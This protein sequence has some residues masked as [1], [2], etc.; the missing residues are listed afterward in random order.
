MKNLLIFFLLFVFGCKLIIPPS[1]RYRI[2]QKG[3]RS[4]T[5]C[6]LTNMSISQ[7]KRD[8][9]SLEDIRPKTK[10]EIYRYNCEIKEGFIGSSFISFEKNNKGYNWS[11]VKA[12]NVPIIIEKGYVYQV[13][14][15][16]DL[17]GSYYFCLDSTSQKLIVQYQ[18]AGPW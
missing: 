15:L 10:I 12:G 9:V 16:C 7:F 18:D 8:D 1:E 2:T 14:G 17:E 5:G 4:K 11:P 3:I 13:F 6:K